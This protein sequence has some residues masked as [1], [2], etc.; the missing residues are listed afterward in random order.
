MPHDSLVPRRAGTTVSPWAAAARSTSATWSVSAGRATSP[1]AHAVDVVGRLRRRGRRR[2]PSRR[3]RAPSG[4]GSPAHIRTPP[5]GRLPAAG[6]RPSCRPGT[7]PH[8]RGVGKTLPGLEMLSGSKAQRTSCIVSRSSSVYIRGMYFA[9][10]MPT[11][12]SPVIEPPCSM[13]RSRIAPLTFSAASPAPSTASSKS[14]SGCRLPSPAWKTLATRTPESLGQVGDRP[15][16]LGQRG[17]RDDAVLD[18]VVGADPADRRER[19]LAALP[20][21]RPVGRVGGEPLLEGAVLVAQPLDLGVL[22]LDLDRGAVELDDEHGA[23]TVGVVAVH[24]RLGGLDRERVHHLDRG[25]HDAGG[26]DRGGRGAGLVGATRSR[27]G[28]C[29]PPRAAGPAGRSPR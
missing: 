24:R 2:R 12:C 26:D 23:G 22:L 16:H 18:D 10:S 7:S 9:L 25:R 3:P 6:G 19:R 8:S 20:D 1:G 29:A 11:P 4:R 17:P 5:P 21:Q 15:E 28:S 14:T 13:Q 27:P